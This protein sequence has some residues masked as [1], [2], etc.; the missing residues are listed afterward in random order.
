MAPSGNVAAIFDAILLKPYRQSQ[1]F[2]AMIR[3]SNTHTAS[4]PVTT[5]SAV[6][7]KNKHILVADDN[8][9]NLKVALAMLAKLGYQA[10]TARNGQEA[11]EMVAQSFATQ[12]PY[13]AILIDANMPVMDGYAAARHIISTYGAAAPPMMALTASVMEEDRQRCIDAGMP[14][15]IPKPLRIDE[16]ADALERYALSPTNSAASSQPTT[17][18]RP[19]HNASAEQPGLIDWTRLDQFKEFDDSR[20]TMARDVIALFVADVPMRL[21]AIEATLPHC[22]PADLSLA[23]HALKGAASNV[24]ARSLVEACYALEKNCNQNTWPATAS[25]QASH[26]AELA[27]LTCKALLLFRPQTA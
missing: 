4:A 6:V 11:V 23:L 19:T 16:L 14:G 21:Q 25:G 7:A 13:A 18:P 20:R 27:Q 5:S 12:Q 22:V 10:S 26:I 9:V 1:L 3:A 2:D 24:G 17:D 15:F 8:A